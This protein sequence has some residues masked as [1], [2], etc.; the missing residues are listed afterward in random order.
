MNPKLYNEVLRTFEIEQNQEYS[1]E[2]EIV[3]FVDKFLEKRM[4]K[5]SNPATASKVISDRQDLL[6]KIIEIADQEK[7][8]ITFSENV[9]CDYLLAFG[10]KNI[11]KRQIQIK[12]KQILDLY[13]N[14]YFRQKLNDPLDI[15]IDILK[16]FSKTKAEIRHSKMLAY[17]LDP[18]ED[19]GFENRP[20]TSLIEYLELDIITDHKAIVKPEDSQKVSCYG[21]EYP[22]IDITIRFPEIKRSLFIETKTGAKER[23]CQLEDYEHVAKQKKDHYGEVQFIYL[24]IGKEDPKR[25][26]KWITLSWAEVA[27]MIMCTI[28]KDDTPHA[29]MARFWVSVLLSDFYNMGTELGTDLQLKGLQDIHTCEAYER[30]FLVFKKMNSTKS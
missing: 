4:Q 12:A 23:D 26:K 10:I 19:H 8:H 1:E 3:R 25:T 6:S 9:A 24:S 14:H 20:L 5:Q 30:Y 7:S 17:L 29:D 13:K 18:S 2:N 28:A 22:R 27:G 11:L 16:P 21:A 15:Y